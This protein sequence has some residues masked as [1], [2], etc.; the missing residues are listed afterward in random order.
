MGWSG[1]GTNSR[2]IPLGEPRKVLD[3]SCHVLLPQS[4]DVPD[5]SSSAS[6]PPGCACRNVTNTQKPM[7]PSGA[8]TPAATGRSQAPKGSRPVRAAP[9]RAISTATS[10]AAI[11]ATADEWTVPASRVRIPAQQDYREQLLP[12][13][14]T[15]E[16]VKRHLNTELLLF[17]APFRVACGWPKRHS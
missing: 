13:G 3:T 1:R 15:L 6:Q 14:S 10:T 16:T 2:L 7:S 8:I 12:G 4:I 9:T 5:F 11:S 17:L